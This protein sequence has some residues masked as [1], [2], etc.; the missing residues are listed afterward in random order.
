MLFGDGDAKRASWANDRNRLLA[1]ALTILEAQT[2]SGCGQPLHEAA[3]DDPPDYSPE[4]Y[5]CAGCAVL[6]QAGSE[7]DEP[8]TKWYLDVT[9][10][11]APSSANT[12]RQ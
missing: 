1:L 4:N 12:P 11:P 6:S 3:S 9:R 2:C 8:G 10:R 7:N 5:R